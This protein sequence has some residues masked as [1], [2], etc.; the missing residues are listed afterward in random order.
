M[1]TRKKDHFHRQN[2][3]EPA[4]FLF[5]LDLLPHMDT[6]AVKAVKE[7]HDVGDGFFLLSFVRSKKKTRTKGSQQVMEWKHAF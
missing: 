3:L 6:A 7:Q 2:L 4:F 1:C 5:H